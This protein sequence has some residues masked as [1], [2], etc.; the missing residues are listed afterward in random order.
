M[1]IKYT[2]NIEKEHVTIN[3]FNETDPIC[4]MRMR[5]TVLNGLISQYM[6]HENSLID[7]KE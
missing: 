5:K 2:L 4:G 7:K 6:R 1:K 3:A